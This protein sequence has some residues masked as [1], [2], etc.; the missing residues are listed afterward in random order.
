VFCGSYHTFV[1]QE[2][3]LGKRLFAFGL[4][5]HGQL[6]TGREYS[7]NEENVTHTPEEVEI[8]EGE[9]VVSAAG[10]EHHSLILTESGLWVLFDW[11]GKVYAFGRG[12][13]SQTGFA[14]KEKRIEPELLDIPGKAIQINCGSAFS[15]AVM[16][17]GGLGDNLVMWGFGDQGQLANGSEDIEV[18]TFI[19]LKGRVVVCA[20]G[21]GQHSILLLKPKDE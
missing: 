21:G 18:P 5:N 1:L 16:D 2:S 12:D 6:G 3:K 13:S 11:I 10:G 17:K 14:D 20:D 4:N 9:V 7:E 8:D 19:P 15:M